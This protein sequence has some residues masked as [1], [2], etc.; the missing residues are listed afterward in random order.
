MIPLK[1]GKEM[2]DSYA[3]NNGPQ[4]GSRKGIRALC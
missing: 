1:T 4:I 2:G 3:G